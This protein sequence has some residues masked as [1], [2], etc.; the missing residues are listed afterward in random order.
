MAIRAPDGANKVDFNEISYSSYAGPRCGVSPRFDERLRAPP[1]LRNAINVNGRQ[2]QHDNNIAKLQKF[3][4]IIKE[5][6]HGTP[7]ASSLTLTLH[8]KW[9]YQPE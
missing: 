8:Q 5:L 2:Y 1:P 3:K 6:C 9:H 4:N 7:T